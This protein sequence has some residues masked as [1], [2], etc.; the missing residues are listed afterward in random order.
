MTSTYIQS[1]VAAGLH[2]PIGIHDLAATDTHLF[3]GMNDGK[4]WKRPLAEIS[5]SIRQSD[6]HTAKWGFENNPGALL[7][8]GAGIPFS[9]FHRP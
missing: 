1:I 9:I 5:I 4:V 8:N 2:Q 6:P 7:G 3:L